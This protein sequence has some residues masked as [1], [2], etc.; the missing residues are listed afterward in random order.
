MVA[1]YFVPETPAFLLRKGQKKDAGKAL[2]WLR[3]AETFEE[4]QDELNEVRVHCY[5][6]TFKI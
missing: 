6:I 5:F 1:M 4:I 3:G 2:M